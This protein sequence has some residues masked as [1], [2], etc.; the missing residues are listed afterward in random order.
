MEHTELGVVLLVE[1]VYSMVKRSR[2][3]HCCYPV[4]VR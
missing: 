1:L 2:D 4:L 3:E